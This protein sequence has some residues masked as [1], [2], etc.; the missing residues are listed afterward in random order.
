MKATARI[1]ALAAC[2]VACATSTREALG[3]SPVPAS[4]TSASASASA[5]APGAPSASVASLPA[6]SIGSVLQAAGVSSGLD[7]TARPAP[8][9]LRHAP[10]VGLT[11][12]GGV[13]LGAYEAGYLYYLTEVAKIP[14]NRPAI[15]VKL[16]TGASAGN[17]NALFTILALCSKPQPNPQRSVFWDTWIRIG[18]RELFR[19]ASPD[20]PPERGHGAFSRSALLGI[21]G[22]LE[23]VFRGGIDASCD[24]VLAVS[25]TRLKSAEVTLRDGFK[26]PRQE[27]K[28]VVRIQGRGPGR[29]PRVTN[30]VDTT[31]ALPQPMLPFPVDQDST[32]GQL[33]TFALLRDLLLASAAFPVAFPPQPLPHC[34][35]P[36]TLRVSTA[37]GAV[38]P[39]AMPSSSAPAGP[40]V[41]PSVLTE[42]GSLPVSTEDFIDGG[43]FDNT[44]LRLA[45]NLS[46]RLDPSGNWRPVGAPPVPGAPR[47]PGG[48]LFID[49]DTAAYP[50]PPESAVAPN[51]PLI[52]QVSSFLS[53]FIATARSK[54]LYTLIQERPDIDVALSRRHF[55]TA[56]GHLANFFGFFEESFRRFDFYLGMYDAHRM[57]LH[58]FPRVLDVARPAAPEAVWDPFV[59]MAS[60]FGEGDPDQAACSPDPARCAALSREDCERKS[61]HAE[62]FRV[63]LQVA[64]DRLHS[65][66]ESLPP[67]VMPTI[68][69]HHC[70]RAN[71]QK[72]RR[73]IKNLPQTPPGA[74]RKLRRESDFEHTLRLLDLYRFRFEDLLGEGILGRGGSVEAMTRV[75]YQ[76]ASLLERTASKQPPGDASVLRLLGKPALNFIY[77]APPPTILYFSLGRGNEVGASWLQNWRRLRLTA[78]LQF[79]GLEEITFS[80]QGEAAF[81]PMIGAEAE[82]YGSAIYQ[83]RLGLRGGYQM[84][85]KG[86]RAS[87][88]RNP[89]ATNSFSASRS[90]CSSFVAQLPFTL[91]IFERVRFQL[92][93]EYLVPHWPLDGKSWNILF[94]VGGQLISPFF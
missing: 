13:S 83:V 81:T 84:S 5:S 60:A 94:G 12:S 82:L 36:G 63:L 50:L 66:C 35:T 87:D 19:P 21:A 75:R 90:D 86:F 48:F 41:D 46:S 61:R 64:I 7:L 56:S 69:H 65:H 10:F 28:F 3:P 9:T 77:Y 89:E 57:A 23:Q 72:P 91:A 42:C 51:L 18:A 17:I 11:V 14:Q 33:K 22:N 45:E 76:L 40:A 85:T 25:T 34:L 70:L 29:A 78:A 44:P 38:A 4:S 71:L 16:V 2:L 79:K 32:D 88:C 30:F 53:G 15:D 43:V 80:D 73:I 67:E 93:P 31:S 54:E 39:G 1:F 92:V 68:E 20:D 49:P 26:V 62:D 74:F 47:M 27:E 37:S 59:C 55:P 24:K 58:S 52:P 8:P 6:P